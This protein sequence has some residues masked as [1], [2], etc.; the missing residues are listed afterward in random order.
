MTA[1]LIV[2]GGVAYLTAYFAIGWHLAKRDLPSQWERARLAYSPKRYGQDFSEKRAREI[3]TSGTLV[4]LFWWPFRLPYIRVA[5]MAA[6]F[7][8]Q[9]IEADR[10]EQEKRIAELERELQ[11]KRRP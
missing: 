5:N 7:D 9:R 3:V 8:P 4:T 1:L 6:R 2:V 11:I 10:V